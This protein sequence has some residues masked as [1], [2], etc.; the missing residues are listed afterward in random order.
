MRSCLLGVAIVLG[1]AACGD[2]SPYVPKDDA[3]VEP[4]APDDNAAFTKFVID[5]V[6][7]H[8]ADVT[9]ADYDSFK[10]LPDP[11]GDNNNTS[12]YGELFQ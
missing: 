1:F 4:D 5:L 2:D 3:A 8:G 10:G 12:A 7:N 6:K 9:P 11:D